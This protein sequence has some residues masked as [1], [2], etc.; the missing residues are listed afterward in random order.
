M[1][2]EEKIKQ[3]FERTAKALSLRDSL[4]RGTAV[5]RVEVKDGYSCQVTDGEWTLSVDM[6]EKHG[7]NNTGPNP[8]VLGR[9]ALGSCLA[10]GYVR[11]AAVL[12]VPID[13]ISVE[14]QADYDAR[15]EFAVSD[16]SPA[17][18]EM[19]YVVTVESDA[20]KEE[21]VAA[22]DKSERFTS[23]LAAFRDPQNVKRELRIVNSVEV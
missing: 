4:G 9:A 21:I 16:V 12:G 20:T 14:I 23:F 7:G 8:G 6:A 2:R 11:W 22:L 17:Y 13:N 5:T 3:A 1:N 15:G 19:R 10:M 18:S